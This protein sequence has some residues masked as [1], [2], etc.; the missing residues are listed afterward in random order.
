MHST[1][2]NMFKSPNNSSTN[3]YYKI[4]LKKD[5][6]DKCKHLK[7]VKMIVLVVFWEE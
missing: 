1:T 7:E 3:H 2:L 6:K 4:Y 5:V